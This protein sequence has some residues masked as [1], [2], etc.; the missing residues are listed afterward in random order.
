MTR[1]FKRSRAKDAEQQARG[2]LRAAPEYADAR[3]A[4]APEQTRRIEQLRRRDERK[5]IEAA[6][7]AVVFASLGQTLRS[8]LLQASTAVRSRHPS[9]DAA[10][11]GAT[12]EIFALADRRVES[13][14]FFQLL[15]RK[16]G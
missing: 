14:Y 7:V 10:V 12:R 15:I 5:L 8:Q 1:S 16:G 9:I 11:I 4:L 3:T 2:V 6:E 13:Y